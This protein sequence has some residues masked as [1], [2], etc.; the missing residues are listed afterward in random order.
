MQQYNRDKRSRLNT[1]HGK[2]FEQKHEL[3]RLFVGNNA[4]QL[5]GQTLTFF[6]VFHPHYALKLVA[7]SAL[8]NVGAPRLRPDQLLRSIVAVLLFIMKFLQG[9]PITSLRH[10]A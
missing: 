8:N 1:N 3:P 7:A 10:V 2:V 6:S 9:R 5:F 4:T